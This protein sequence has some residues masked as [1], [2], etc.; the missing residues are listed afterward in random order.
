MNAIKGMVFTPECEFLPGIV[1]VEGNV[2]EKVEYVTPEEL[3]DA[4]RDRY[5]TPGL[6]DIHMHGC[7]GH[8][9]CD[10]SVE[11]IQS[12]IAYERDHGITSICLATMTLDENKLHNVLHT[13]SS[14]D[15]TN[16]KGI[17]LE[18]PFINVEKKGAQGEEDIVSPDYGMLLRLNESAKGKIV[19]VSIA[20]EIDGAFSCIN[21]AKDEFSF[22]LGHS[23]ADYNT[24]VRAFDAGVKQVTHLYN[25]MS[26]MNHRSPG[27]VF[28][29]ADD[30][31]VMVEL[32]TDG[33]HV[34]PSVVRNTFKLFGDDRIVLISDSMEATGMANGV[35]SLGGQSVHVS[36]K[37]ALLDDG[38][39]AGSASN[40]FECMQT[41]IKMGIPK[42][43]ALKAATANPAKAIGIYDKVGSIEAG[44]AADILILNHD[45]EL[46]EVIQDI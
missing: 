21:D 17:Y 43:I 1:Y 28:A 11:G 6:I 24:A 32:I 5:V 41:A 7:N 37:W 23:A 16:L 3:S 25:A 39:I 22:T 4:E 9:A 38:T 31:D 27:I 40:L 34:H 20:P 42:N 36:N 12:I 46:E 2:I 29:A 15:N 18:G 45:F 44:K 26:P 10:S 14:V 33:I 30:D 13:I 35:Y 8:D 19:K